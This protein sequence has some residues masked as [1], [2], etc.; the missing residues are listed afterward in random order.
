ME[1]DLRPHDARQ[2]PCPVHGGGNA[3]GLDH[4]DE[5]GTMIAQEPVTRQYRMLCQRCDHTWQGTYVIRTFHDDA[6]DHELFYRN[7]APSIGPAATLCPYCDGLRVR[8]LPP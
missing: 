2:R 4:S 7:G 8:I 5:E 3:A 1:P 6:G